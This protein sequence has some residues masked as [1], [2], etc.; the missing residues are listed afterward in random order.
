VDT[1]KVIKVTR[2]LTD[3][4][5]IVYLLVEGPT[6]YPELDQTQPGKYP[7][8]VQLHCRYGYGSEWVRLTFGRPEDE[9]IDGRR[10]SLTTCGM[11]E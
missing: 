4:D 7:P 5:D 1:L 11:H 6:P 3:S 8:S 10:K 2:L 9:L